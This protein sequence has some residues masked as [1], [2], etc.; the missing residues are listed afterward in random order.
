[1]VQHVRD[2]IAARKARRD[3]DELTD[4]DDPLA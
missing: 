4:I 1:M 3:T 2:R